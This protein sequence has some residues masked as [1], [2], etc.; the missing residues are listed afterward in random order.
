MYMCILHT[1][2]TILV[3][4]VQRA[5]IHET[6]LRQSGTALFL[7]KLLVFH[8]WQSLSNNVLALVKSNRTKSTDRWMVDRQA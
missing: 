8:V 1:L 4:S 6:N 5:V 2:D 7:V 3:R